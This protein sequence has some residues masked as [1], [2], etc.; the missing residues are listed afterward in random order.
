MGSFKLVVTKDKVKLRQD[1][2]TVEKVPH[3]QVR[4]HNIFIYRVLHSSRFSGNLPFTLFNYLRVH[5]VLLV[6]FD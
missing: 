6:F 2:F 5:V 1:G 3:G 4:V